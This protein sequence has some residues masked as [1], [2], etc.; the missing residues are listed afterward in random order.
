MH[1]LIGLIVTVLLFASLRAVLPERPVVTALLPAAVIGVLTVYYVRD[2]LSF[3]FWAGSIGF[4]A[5]LSALLVVM[6]PNPMASVLFLILHL[7]C[8]ALFYLMLQ[9]QVLAALQVIV[10][11][12]A[13]MVLFVFVVMLLNLKAEEGLRLGGGAQRAAAVLVGAAFAGL[14][15]W[16]IRNRRG[17]P[18]FAPDVPIDGFGTARE[19]GWL[20]YG[21]YLFAFEAASIL[22]V[23][24]MVGAVVLAKRRLS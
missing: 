14:M 21:K 24:A 16:A 15:F 4:V 19:L 1:L 9:A 20:L 22:L 23:A 3:E 5:I 2:L 13:I 8:I 12:G 18:F 7:F 6:H 11:A 10:Y 17:R